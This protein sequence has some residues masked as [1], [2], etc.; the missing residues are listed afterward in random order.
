MTVYVAFSCVIMWSSALPD[1]LSQRVIYVL[2]GCNFGTTDEYGGD[3]VAR[4]CITRC[5]GVGI[6][7]VPRVCLVSADDC[8]WKSPIKVK[9][10]SGKRFDMV[11]IALVI[12]G[13]QLKGSL[14]CTSYI[15]RNVMC[16]LVVFSVV[17]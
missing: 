14:C 13:T 15:L 11:A 3:D 9:D 12:A 4:K 16:A 7:S 8:A 17:H 2:V 5:L 10:V 6:G 1:V